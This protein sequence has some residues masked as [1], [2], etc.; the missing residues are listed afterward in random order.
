[1]I[2]T[3]RLILRRWR[4]ADLEPYAAMM[5]DP[6]VADWLGGVL[7]RAAVEARIAR[8]EAGFETQGVG[9]FALERREDGAFLGYC[10]LLKIGDGLPVGPGFEIGWGLSRQAWGG[11]YATEAAHAAVA[12]GFARLGLPEIL[13]YTTVGNLRSQAVMTR[14]G[15]VRAPE[16]DFNHTMFEVGHPLCRHL[17]FVA[18]PA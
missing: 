8:S 12:D 14:A 10:G 6:E 2:E 17:V 5:A 1:V 16:R 18:T 15:F 9:R 11:G 7:D 4:E 3:E 13:A